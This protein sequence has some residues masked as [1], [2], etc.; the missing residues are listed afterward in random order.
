MI[1]EKDSLLIFVNIIIIRMYSDS[2]AGDLGIK[3]LR[4][5]RNAIFN[6]WIRN[7]EDQQDP[8]SCKGQEDQ[9]AG[10]LEG[11]REA[12]RPSEGSKT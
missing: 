1:S 5:G 11:R 4:I 2:D 8:K 3:G 12:T 9:K 6:F 10:S 7:G